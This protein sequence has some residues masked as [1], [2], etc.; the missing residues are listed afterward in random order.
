MKSLPFWFVFT[1]AVFALIGMAWG[2]QMSMTQDHTLASAHAH[3]NLV[4]FVVM[5]IYGVYYRLVPGAANTALA[6][7]HFWLALASAAIIGIGIALAVMG[8]TPVVAIIASLLTIA[9]MAIFV[10]TVWTNREGLTNV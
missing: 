4:G 2:I 7:I 5:T 6:R 9:A 8:T 10:W 3:N 1:G